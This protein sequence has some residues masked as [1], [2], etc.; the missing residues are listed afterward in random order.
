MLKQIDKY[1]DKL[2]D[3]PIEVITSKGEKII[4]YPQRTNNLME[5]GFRD[6]KSGFRKKSGTK[7][8]NKKLMQ[9]LRVRH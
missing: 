9:C 2:F 8:L 7:S 4:R 1:W 6:D 5:V 3:D